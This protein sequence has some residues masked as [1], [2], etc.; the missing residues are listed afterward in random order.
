MERLALVV[1]ATMLVGRVVC[2]VQL[3]FQAVKHVL[4]R[5]CVPPAMQLYSTSMGQSVLVIVELIF[6]GQLV[7]PVLFPVVPIAQALPYATLVTQ[8]HIFRRVV[9]PASV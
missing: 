3:V 8:Q 5:L 2:N 9:Q 7:Q 1:L 4:H 6:Q